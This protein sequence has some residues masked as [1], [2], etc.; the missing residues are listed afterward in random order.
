MKIR[1]FVANIDK[2]FLKND[3]D[4]PIAITGRER[5]GKSTLALE[6]AYLLLKQQKVRLQWNKIIENNIGY[7]HEEVIKKIK[8]LPEQSPFIADESIRGMYKMDFMS[9][10][11]REMVKMFSQIGMKNDLFLF[12]IPRFWDLLENIRNHRVKFWVHIV[13]RGYAVVFLPDENQFISDPWNR[14]ENEKTIAF[15]TSL[16][17]TRK[18]RLVSLF[19][20]PMD[21]IDLYSKCSNYMDWF[22][23]KPMPEK[24]FAPYVELSEK[25]KMEH[26]AEGH[27]VGEKM[28]IREYQTLL[29]YYNRCNQNKRQASFLIKKELGWVSHEK[30]I[31]KML[32]KALKT[33]NPIGKNS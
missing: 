23:F 31:A 27:D 21:I 19:D 3:D 22:K 1:K 8:A 18:K 5:V 28:L 4:C 13:A 30:H 29:A 15:G 33:L 14:T 17:K 6:M 10:Q 9:V 32:D 7:R 25:R 11:G 2:K 16:R 24:L 12:N 26:D 20:E